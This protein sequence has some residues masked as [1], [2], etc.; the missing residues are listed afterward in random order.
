MLRLRLFYGLLTITLLLWGVGGAALLLMRDSSEKYSTHLREDYRAIAAAQA[1]RAITSTLNTHYLPVLA[2][3]S[4]ETKLDRDLFD[5][6]KAEQENHLNLI[7]EAAKR[8]PQWE[9]TASRYE[10]AVRLYHEGYERYFKSMPS[11]RTERAELLRYLSAQTQRMTDLSEALM[12]LG[13]AN[14]FKGTDNLGDETGKNVLLIATLILLGT[15]IAALVYYQLVRHLVDPV[16][17]LTHSIEEIR[18][19]NFELTLPVPGTDSEFASVASAFNHMAAELRVSRLKTDES[20]SR[21][22]LVNRAILQSIP[23]P[24]YV[25]DDDTTVVQMNPA[26]E[27][28]S[29]K[30]GVTSRLPLKIQSIFDECR[31]HGTHFL[32]EDP[33]E[34]L[35]FRIDE[36]EYYYLPRIFRFE[37]DGRSGEGKSGWAVLLHNVSRIRWLDDMKTNLIATVSHEIK[38]PLTGIRMVLHLLLEERN[39]K[40]DDL[41]KTM[42]ASA[43]E[44]CERLLLTLNSMLELSRAESGTTHLQR[45]NTSLL[46]CVENAAKNHTSQGQAKNITLEVDSRVSGAP[47]VFIDPLRLD[48]VLNHLISNAIRYSPPLAKVILRITK[49]EADF[50]RVSIIDRGPGVPEEA[51]SRIFERFYRAPGAEGEGVGLGLFISREIMRAHEGRIGLKERFNDLTEFYID[52]PIA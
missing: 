49:P 36:K 8:N 50:L 30:L 47:E 39:N 6:L 17:G 46:R 1:S 27:E 20:L 32:P 19:G 24:V 5:R 9:D 22:N 41:Q 31:E 52:V 23:S 43:T 28:L 11:L 10:M 26:A 14:L 25:L 3:S 2:L 33:R 4:E 38:T 7:K 40:L 16:S 51:Q 29:E 45:T 35:L 18:K 13:E 34:A 21:A 44:D 15:S 37:A 42:V 12:K 48:E